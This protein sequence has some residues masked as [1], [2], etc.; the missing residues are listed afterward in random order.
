[1]PDQLITWRAA[2][3]YIDEAYMVIDSLN[4]W[5]KRR[6]KFLDYAAIRADVN[7]VSDT[8]IP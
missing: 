7:S 5:K 3:A 4:T 8:K 2:A 6:S 1:M